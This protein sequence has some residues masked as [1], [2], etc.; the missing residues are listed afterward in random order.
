VSVRITV[1][2]SY[3]RGLKALPPDR[4]KAANAAIVKFQAE[5]GLPSLRFRQLKGRVDHFIINPTRGDRIIL[6]RDAEDLYAVID[7][8]PHDNVLRRWDR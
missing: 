6:R 3:G 8:G 2:P 7:V 5:P 4:R 1:E